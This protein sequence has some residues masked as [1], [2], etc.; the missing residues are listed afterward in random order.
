MNV[1]DTEANLKQCAIFFDIIQE[2][3]IQLRLDTIK[4]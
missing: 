1:S 3:V 4:T 2:F